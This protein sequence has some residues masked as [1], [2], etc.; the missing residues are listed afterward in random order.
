MRVYF[1]RHGDAE[2]RRAGLSDSERR[3]TG[4]GIEEMRAVARGMKRLGLEFDRILTSPYLR[5]RETAAIAAEA[6]KQQD[7]LREEPGLRSG[8]EFRDLL[9]VLDAVRPDER[10]LLV[11]HEPDFSTFV[12]AIIGGGAM[13][14]RKAG[15]AAVEWTPPEPGAGELLFLLAPTHLAAMGGD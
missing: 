11:G 2:D 9:A 7:R 1:L 14:M 3:L 8:C 10:V 15:L 13:R 12:S 5:A 4:E 6:L